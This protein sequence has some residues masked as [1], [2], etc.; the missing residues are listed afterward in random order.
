MSYRTVVISNPSFLQ[1]CKSQLQITQGDDI[2]T[3]PLEDIA[4]IVLNHYQI[5][6]SA[7]LLSGC[8]DNN[9]VLI[10]CDN[11]HLPNGIFH[12]YLPHSRQNLVLQKQLNLSQAFKKRMWQSIVQSKI[13]NQATVTASVTKNTT[14]VSK[15]LYELAN[16]VSSGDKENIEAQASRIYFTAIFGNEFVRLDKFKSSISDNH[17]NEK[18]NS[19]LNYSY[20]IIRS[21]IIRSIVGYGLLPTLGLFHDNQLNAFNLADDFIEPFR[22]YIDWY[23]YMLI[24]EQA[25]I[26]LTA[27]TKAKL[28]DSL[29]YLIV[30][31]SKNTTILNTVDIMI[32]SFITCINNNDYEQLLLPSIPAKLVRSNIH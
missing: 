32:K 15:Q 22:A 7:N 13:I 23:V 20:T 29:N 21:V 6:L 17:I 14:G 12:S 5:S 18:I 25:D 2:Y 9:I 4:C 24:F 16:K 19:L 3:V 26:E 8:A 1:I 27:I 11:K 10:S 30:I 31:N 28:I